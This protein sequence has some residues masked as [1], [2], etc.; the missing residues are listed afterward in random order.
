[1]I[2]KTW[3]PI[4]YEKSGLWEPFPGAP[5]TLVDARVLHKDGLI[6]MAQRRVMYEPFR[7]S[8]H[9]QIVVKERRQ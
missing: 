6:L 2:P 1:M 8:P 3:T 9:M 5:M 4:A 7:P